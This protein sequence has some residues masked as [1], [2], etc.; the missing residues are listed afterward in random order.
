M[1]NEIKLLIKLQIVDDKLK[2]VE[3]ELGDL[4]EQVERLKTTL[5]DG[6]IKINQYLQEIKDNRVKRE[7][8]EVQVDEHRE[9]LN[10]HKEKLFMVQ[11]NREYDAINSEIDQIQ[12]NIDEN[13]TQVINLISREDELK[14]LVE[15]LQTTQKEAGEEF[16]EKYS[17]LN[18]KLQ[19]TEGEKIELVHQREKFVMLVKKPIYAHYE[20]IRKVRDGSGVAFIVNGACGGCFS[21]IPPQKQVEIG[22]M[23]DLNLCEV[24]GRFLVPNPDNFNDL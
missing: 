21:A 17:E 12:V 20:R 6:E 19:E 13:E 14:Q 4:P 9:K 10:Q 5:E 7:S 3:M 24:C 23:T 8:L 11:T 16:R 2:E 22:N 1:R 18:R 15:E